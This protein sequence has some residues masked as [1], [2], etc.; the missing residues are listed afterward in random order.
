MLFKQGCVVIGTELN[1][2]YR[3]WLSC[4]VYCFG[5]VNVNK[6]QTSAI[7]E[8]GYSSKRLIRTKPIILLTSNNTGWVFIVEQ[9]IISV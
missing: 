9:K 8:Q 7:V 5:Y 6:K 4:G 3:F 2:L 1:M